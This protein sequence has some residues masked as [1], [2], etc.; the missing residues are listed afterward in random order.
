MLTTEIAY[1]K[2]TERLQHAFKFIDALAE[3]ESSIFY[4]GKSDVIKHVARNLHGTSHEATGRQLSNY[5]ARSANLGYNTYLKTYDDPLTLAID[6]STRALYE[7]E[8]PLVSTNIAKLR[9]LVKNGMPQMPAIYAR[10]EPFSAALDIID[11]LFITGRTS[12]EL[13]KQTMDFI[14]LRRDKEGIFKGYFDR[15]AANYN[16][17]RKKN[18]LAVKE[19]VYSWSTGSQAFDQET[20]ATVGKVFTPDRW[21][22][23]PRIRP[24]AETVHQFLN[25]SEYPRER[26]YPNVA[27]GII[28]AILVTNPNFELEYLSERKQKTLERALSDEEAPTSERN[29]HTVSELI[30]LQK[31]LSARV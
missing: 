19:N 4:I 11:L 16:I 24:A 23:D 28:H 25:N 18:L 13:F 15:E 10:Q 17:V 30:Q 3:D 14:F 29:L 8:D 1:Q 31:L 9:Y 7:S 22:I 20:N 26:R 27:L 12:D 5:V 21:P 2:I 6:A